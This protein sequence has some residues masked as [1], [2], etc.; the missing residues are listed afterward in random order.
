MSEMLDRIEH[1]ILLGRC[2][3]SSNREIAKAVLEAMREPTEN[4]RCA[5]ETAFRSWHGEGAWKVGIDAALG[6]SALTSP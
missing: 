5:L 3:D 6:R 2:S 1:I 4:V